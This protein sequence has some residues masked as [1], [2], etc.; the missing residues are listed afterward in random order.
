MRCRFAWPGVVALFSALLVPRANA[1]ADSPAPPSPQPQIVQP[2]R[3]AR[4]APASIPQ[5][6]ALTSFPP[7]AA[8]ALLAIRKLRHRL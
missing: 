2:H 6:T 7:L 3:D 8:A 5:P 1:K 4:P